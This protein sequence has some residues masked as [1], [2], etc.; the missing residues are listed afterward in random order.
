MD[1]VD[2]WADAAGGAGGTA[3]LAYTGTR[4]PSGYGLMDFNFQFLSLENDEPG[5]GW[6]PVRRRARPAAHDA[7]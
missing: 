6:R 7:R 4:L 5:Y 2:R 3:S 1:A